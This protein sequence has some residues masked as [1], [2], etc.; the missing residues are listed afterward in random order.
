MNPGTATTGPSGAG[1]DVL[2]MLRRCTWRHWTRSPGQAAV[3]VLILA[4]GI[5]VYFA[6]RLANRAAMGG[7]QD[8]T[9]LVT[10]GGDWIVT[11]PVGFLPDSV[12]PE[13]RQALG[14][15]PVHVI[16]ILE[17]TATRPRQSDDEEIGSRETLQILGLDLVA[18]GNLRPADDPSPTGWLAPGDAPGK[19]TEDQGTRRFFEL[20]GN[21]RSV[22]ISPE[23]AERDGL[24]TGDS[25]RLVVNERVVDLE[26]RGRIP[27]LPAR[28]APPAELLV[29]DLPALQQL[30]ARTGRIDRVEL[31][32]EDGPDADARRAGLREL[33][34]GLG[35]DRWEVTSPGDRRRTAEQMT[36]AFR[37]NLTLLSLLALVVGLYLVFQAL[38]G[39]VVRRR[40]EIGILRSLGVTES[41][42]RRAWLLE[43][44]V[45][46]L[47]GGALGALL[48]W[49]GAQ[50]AVRLVGRTVNA[51]YHA[52]HARSAALHP[53][54]FAGALALAV[55]GGLVAGWGPARAAARTPAAQLLGRAS[56][57][58]GSA[59]NRRRLPWALGLLAMAGAAALLPPV[60]LAGGARLALGGYLAACLVVAG[61]GLAGG[62]L[63]ARLARGATPLALRNARWR[64]AV[65]QARRPSGRHRLAVAALVCAVGMTAGM[66]ILVASFDRTM[67]GWIRRT[68]QADLY[69][70]SDGAQSA[71]TQN[72]ITPSTWRAVLAHPGVGEANVIQVAEVALPAGRTLLV[73]SDLAFARKHMGFS[74]RG[75]PP[76]AA[77]FDPDRN[78]GLA[79]ASESFAT[80]FRIRAGDTLAVPTPS[81]PRPVRV[82]GIFSDY[83]N[84]RGSLVVD[85]RW[86]VEWFGDE[87]A[88]SLI[89]FVQPGHPPAAVRD[90]LRER[91]PGLSILTQGRLR[92]EVLRIFRQTFALTHALELIGVAVS[93]LGL[94]LTLV[95]MLLDRRAELTTLRALG[96]RRNEIAVATAAE[97]ALIATAGTLL[98]L[99]ASLGLGVVLVRVINRQTF[100]WT[101]EL[102]VPAAPLAL[103]AVGVVGSATAVAWAV[104]RWGADLPADRESE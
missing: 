2:L 31:R 86:F 29:M 102:A 101:L 4:L 77:V 9:G 17:T 30:T 62:P 45:L 60:P 66:S 15:R 52:T 81:G 51:L 80:R 47:A 100:G 63:L 40:E 95:S 25:L 55:A 72:R 10:E 28:P 58:A 13:I 24:R 12:L 34:A 36:A 83:G 50:G 57:P 7:F 76:D 85:R 73:G 39:A 99:A 42:V 93:V 103:L 69:I 18:L 68:F 94:A 44:A 70:S 90:A 79:L 97:G 21:P 43:S 91:F 8:F 89:A 61:T 54:E 88:S 84:E 87:L 71:S 11:S 53:G 46:G 35:A 75:A 38:D 41:A 48:G 22:F 78:A 49:A 14:S 33:L 64:L 104:G 92:D 27:V 59:D 5:A 26:V 37:F 6:V 19:G 98:G 32:V 16:P 56:A 20:L 3:L 82:A 1:R 67:Q 65:G 96:L 23:L 74:W